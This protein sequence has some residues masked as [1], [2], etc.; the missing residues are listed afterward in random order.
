MVGARPFERSLILKSNTLRIELLAIIEVVDAQIKVLRDMNQF[1]LDSSMEQFKVMHRAIEAIIV[2][3]ESFRGEVE[4]I[5]GDLQASQ[6]LVYISP[7]LSR[8]R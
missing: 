3:R 7:P 5:L 8:E 2:G 1:Q 4:T 6:Q